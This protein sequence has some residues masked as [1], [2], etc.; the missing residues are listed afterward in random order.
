MCLTPFITY[1]FVPIEIYVPTIAKHFTTQ[2]WAWVYLG[3]T[4]I[5]C[6]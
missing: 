2:M 1:E 3:S 5:V 6:L 4:W